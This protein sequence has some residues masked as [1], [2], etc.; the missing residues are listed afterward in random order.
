MFLTALNIINVSLVVLYAAT[1]LLY[2][3]HF[4]RD[5]ETKSFL[6][7]RLL[8][9]TL[10]VHLAH[11]VAQGVFHQNI[12][13]GNK[14][15]FLALIALAI[16]T[17][18]AV[19]EYRAKETHTGVFFVALALPFQLLSAALIETI[20]RAEVLDANPLFG[21]HV[22]CLV[23]GI[24]ALSIGA[25]WSVM[26]LLLAHQLKNHELGVFFKRLPPLVKLEVM[27]RGSTIAGIGLLGA[28]LGLGHYIVAQLPGVTWM[29]PKIILMDLVWLA[30]V[31]GLGFVQL[32]GFSG[33]R[34]G[35]ISLFGYI[36]LILTI[37]ISNVALSSFHSFQ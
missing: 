20:S 9:T 13:L 26:Y 37:V 28:G 16:A 14:S 7:T 4:M 21:V 30:Y 25:I 8:Y 5:T 29:D 33:R 1:L 2:A 22:V 32:R 10:G 6:G 31:V 19:I 15:E 27:S 35:Y 18:Y 12:P 3:R 11:T 23:M 24:T 34:V 17:I 36:G